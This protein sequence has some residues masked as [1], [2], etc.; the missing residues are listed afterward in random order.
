MRIVNTDNFASDYPD[1][2][3]V[4]L[5]P[6]SKEVLEKICKIVNDATG[7]DS[8]RYYKVVE[9]DYKLPPGFEP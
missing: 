4:N 8:P 2:K 7:R 6:L 5:P 9:N 1:E 3:F